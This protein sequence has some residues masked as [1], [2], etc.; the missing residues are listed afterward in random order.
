M[1]KIEV[2]GIA[3]SDGISIAPV[4]LLTEPDLTFDRTTVEDAEAEAVRFDIAVE[5]ATAEI[6]QIR[7]I[8]EKS[9]GEEEDK[10]SMLT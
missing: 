1:T 2:T 5:Q 9:L 7:S 6:T 4:Y 8:A 10:F 3:A